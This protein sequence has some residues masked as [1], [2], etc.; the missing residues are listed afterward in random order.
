MKNQTDISVNYLIK[1]KIAAS[2]LNLSYDQIKRERY[3]GK[4]SY[5]KF[6]RGVRYTKK[7]LQDYINSHRVEAT[8]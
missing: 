4:I 5:V 8:N 3:K 7:Q 2:I 1:E 6:K